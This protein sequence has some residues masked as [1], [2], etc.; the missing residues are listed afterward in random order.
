[1]ISLLT[2]LAAL[3]V[4]CTTAIDLSQINTVAGSTNTTLSSS[5]DRADQ[6]LRLANE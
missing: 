2:V 5:D 1:M 6:L 3:T 4:S